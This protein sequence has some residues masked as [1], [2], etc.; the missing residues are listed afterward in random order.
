MPQAG[1]C[2]SQGAISGFLYVYVGCTGV[3]FG[4]QLFRYDP[5]TNTWLIRAAPPVQHAG[6][7][8]GAIGSR[9][10]LA[11]GSD[12]GAQSTLTTHGYIPS[13]NR[14]ITRASMPDIQ[15][16]AAF[17]VLSGRLLVAG[18]S[19]PNG[20]IT[21]LRIYTAASNSW[22]TGAPMTNARFFAAGAAG[23]GL[24]YA[25]GGTRDDGSI[26]PV[27]EAYTP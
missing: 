7:A 11:G 22:A 4:D 13:T 10:Y 8:G 25:I 9:F 15:S 6:G 21:S 16:S 17:N 14:W 26:S 27:V 23:A 1:S 5:A 20:A 2:G 3:P 12:D 24:F 18:G 19:D